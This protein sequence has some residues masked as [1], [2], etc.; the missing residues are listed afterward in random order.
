MN[1]SMQP[2]LTNFDS[3]LLNISSSSNCVSMLFWSHFNLQ[4]LKWEYELVFIVYGVQEYLKWTK[5]ENFCNKYILYFYTWIV[6]KNEMKYE[7]IYLSIKI[8]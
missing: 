5:H 3:S 6:L 2:T 4:D 1:L 7:Y 8:T